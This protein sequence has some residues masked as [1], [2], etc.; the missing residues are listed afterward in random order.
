MSH[1]HHAVH[2]ACSRREATYTMRVPPPPYTPLVVYAVHA[3]LMGA[4]VAHRRGSGRGVVALIPTASFSHRQLCSVG[5]VCL[6]R[7][8][9][10]LRIH[11][12]RI[13][14]AKVPI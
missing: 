2:H 3:P 5:A 8:A 1:V 10:A 4:A 14:A 11:N 12:Q 13:Y 7:A 9:D 6:P